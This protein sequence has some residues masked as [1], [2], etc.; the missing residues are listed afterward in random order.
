MYEV[1]FFIVKITALFFY[2]CLI[3]ALS[4]LLF[5]P[6]IH[7]IIKFFITIFLLAFIGL[8]LMTLEA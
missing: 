2:A 1:G 5:L 6:E 3:M 4:A 7:L 8:F